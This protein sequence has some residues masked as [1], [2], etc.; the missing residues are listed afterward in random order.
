MADARHTKERAAWVTTRAGRR[1]GARRRGER[2]RAAGRRIDREGTG[3]GDAAFTEATTR[4]LFYR[5]VMREEGAANTAGW[6]VSTLLW[7]GG[8]FVAIGPALLIAKAIY[9]V[10]WLVIPVSGPKDYRGKRAPGVMQ[11]IPLW[12]ASA[13]TAAAAVGA[14]FAFESVH[15][16]LY[17]YVAAQLAIA[18]ARAARLTRAY[19]WP[20][21]A[22]KTKSAGG[23]KRVMEISAPAYTAHVVEI[24]RDEIEAAPVATI[25]A[26][27]FTFTV[28]L[29]D[30]LLEPE[31]ADAGTFDVELDV[32][33]TDIYAAM[34]AE[35]ETSF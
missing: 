14:W 26:P 18:S 8:L 19:G 30:D 17:V 4:S 22:A 24:V 10:W 25:P 6:L 9:G 12:I 31:S 15:T 11:A 3:S 28:D 33:P 13:A 2:L 23:S 29:P 27:G 16:F 7:M 21:V 35:D 1:P 5:C 20:A 32:D 34:S